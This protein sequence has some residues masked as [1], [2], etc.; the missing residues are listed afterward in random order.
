MQNRI[1]LFLL[2]IFFVVQANANSP[3]Y[4]NYLPYSD[5]KKHGDIKD[6]TYYEAPI[7]TSKEQAEYL[8]LIN[9]WLAGKFSTD[10]LNPS[11]SELQKKMLIC[12]RNIEIKTW[13]DLIKKNPQYFSQHVTSM[14]EKEIVKN[15]AAMGMSCD[16]VFESQLKILDQEWK[17]M[18]R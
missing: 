16:K 18:H 3:L 10:M 5:T 2:T 12:N 11:T 14:L 8:N 15:K 17:D 13:I 6:N 4:L 1:V 7:L 9:G